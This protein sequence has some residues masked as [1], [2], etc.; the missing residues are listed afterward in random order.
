MDVNRSSWGSI[1]SP[2][3]GLRCGPWHFVLFLQG[4]QPWLSRGRVGEAL[5]LAA[6]DG[7]A[8]LGEFGDC[9]GAGGGPKG[10]GQGPQDGLSS[11]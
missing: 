5:H 10:T 7:R 3:Q 11:S 6:Q 1:P 4:W 9:V 2:A 8:R